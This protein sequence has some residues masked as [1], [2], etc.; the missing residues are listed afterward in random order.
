MRTAYHFNAGKNSSLVKLLEEVDTLDQ[1]FTNLSTSPR[2]CYCAS[3]QSS[4]WSVPKTLGHGG[5]S[6][7]IIAV[8]AGFGPVT[9]QFKQLRTVYV[10]RTPTIFRLVID[11]FDL[12]S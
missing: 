11:N 12:H 7:V 10:Q 8:A 9:N 6:G 3:V 1:L 2:N 5:D 4:Q